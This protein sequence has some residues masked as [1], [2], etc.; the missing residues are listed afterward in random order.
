MKKV[1]RRSKTGFTLLEVLLATVIMVIASTMIMKGFIAVMVIGHNSRS[2]AR[3]GESNYRLAMNQ[4]LA[5]NATAADQIANMDSLA[6]G[7]YSEVT[8]EFVA[9]SAPGVNTTDMRLIVDVDDFADDTAGLSYNVDGDD[10]DNSSVVNN[11]FAFFYDFGD[12]VNQ[13]SGGHIIRYG[14]TVDPANP[15][16][17]HGNYTTPIYNSNGNLVAYGWYGW[18]CFNEAHSGENAC[19]FRSSPYTATR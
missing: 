10:I 12:F 3:S 9:N 1:R 2:Y 15:K 6:D 11:R 19:A 13:G 16:S 5:K 18:Y 7:D 14:Y 4:T 8:A 17:S